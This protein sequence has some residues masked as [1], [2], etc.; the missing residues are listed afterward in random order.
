MPISSLMLPCTLAALSAVIWGIES[1]SGGTELGPTL[2]HTALTTLTGGKE[3][4]MGLSF[5]CLFR[6]KEKIDYITAS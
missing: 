4:S 5:Q 1:H 6:F 2:P 3:G